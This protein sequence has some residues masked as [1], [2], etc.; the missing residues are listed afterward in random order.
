MPTSDN[1]D[2]HRGTGRLRARRCLGAGSPGARLG[3]TEGMRLPVWAAALGIVVVVALL[4][5]VAGQEQWPRNEGG[6][7]EEEEGTST[8]IVFGAQPCSAA[9]HAAA[10]RA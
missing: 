6:E 1:A 3:L 4:E 8:H 2:G 5:P 10:P 9:V 7:E